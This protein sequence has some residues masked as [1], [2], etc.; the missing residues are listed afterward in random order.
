[1]LV[2]L[3]QQLSLVKVLTPSWADEVITKLAKKYKDIEFKNTDNP[4]VQLT[5][6][7]LEKYSGLKI[8]RK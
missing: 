2:I 7:T 3:I 8:N 6:K 4:T 5:I 1:L